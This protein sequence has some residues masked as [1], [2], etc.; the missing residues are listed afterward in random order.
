VSAPA[1]TVCALSVDWSILTRVM[2]GRDACGR[3]GRSERAA[4]YRWTTSSPYGRGSGDHSRLVERMDM[5]FLVT[6]TTQVPPETLGATEHHVF[7]D[8]Y[9]DPGTTARTAAAMTTHRQDINGKCPSGQVPPCCP[10]DRL[11][12]KAFL[13]NSTLER[14][15]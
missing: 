2:Y 7:G 6:M 13:D 4:R 3:S 12:H 10:S 9:N 5:G 11:R 15:A 1:L 8:P 14:R